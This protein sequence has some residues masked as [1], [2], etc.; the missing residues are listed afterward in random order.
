V[1]VESC[2]TQLCALQMYRPSPCCSSSFSSH[3]LLLRH[4]SLEVNVALN[5]GF[6][7]FG[8]QLQLFPC[9]YTQTHNIECCVP[10]MVCWYTL[11]QH[12]IIH[13]VS[14]RLRCARPLYYTST[15]LYSVHFTLV[16]HS[17]QFKSCMSNVRVTT[18]HAR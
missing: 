17:V 18:W 10:C 12:A 6:G 14:Y 8:L 15:D 3:V 5:A 11:S 1:A 4:S 9:K 7:A 2:Y 16:V 13:F